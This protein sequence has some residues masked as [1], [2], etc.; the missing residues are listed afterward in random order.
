[1]EASILEFHCLR[2]A[3]L[4]QIALYMDQVLLVINSALAPLMAG[5]GS[6][7]TATMINNYVKMKL[8]EPAEKKKYNRSHMARFVMICLLKKVLSMQEIAAI[9][10]QLSEGRSE[11][12]SYD[13]FCRELEQRLAE[14]AGPGSCGCPPAPAAAIRALACKIQV[15]QLLAAG[16]AE[17]ETAA[18]VCKQNA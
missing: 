11:E 6:A 3:E 8:A 10:A 17:Q 14:P 5:G 4:P 1:M 13:L 18:P 12:A 7:V 16:S 2:W 9:L 15:E